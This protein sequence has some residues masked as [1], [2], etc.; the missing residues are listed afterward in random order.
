[1]RSLVWTLVLVGTTGAVGCAP[2]DYYPHHETSERASDVRK[3]GDGS[4]GGNNSSYPVGTPGTTADRAAPSEPPA[5]AS[6]PSLNTSG[7]GDFS[8]TGSYSGANTGG[9]TPSDQNASPGTTA[10]GTAGGH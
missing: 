8:P 10:T 9:S 2:V 7:R 4:Y 5:A 1:M 6:G 3:Q